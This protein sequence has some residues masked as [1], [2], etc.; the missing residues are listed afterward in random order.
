MPGQE[1]P[2]QDE[3]F[4]HRDVLTDRRPVKPQLA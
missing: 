4:K 2:H 3:P 1:P